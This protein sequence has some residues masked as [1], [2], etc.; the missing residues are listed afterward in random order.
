[1]TEVDKIKKAV[2]REELD[3]SQIVHSADEPSGDALFEGW[4]YIAKLNEANTV[5]F[6]LWRTPHQVVDA[7]IFGGAVSPVQMLHNR[8]DRDELYSRHWR[9]A[10]MYA[11]HRS[12]RLAQ[13]ADGGEWL[14][15]KDFYRPIR[16]GRETKRDQIIRSI[17]AHSMFD[18]VDFIVDLLRQNEPLA[19]LLLMKRFREALERFPDVVKLPWPDKCHR[20]WEADGGGDF[21]PPF[22][23]LY[24]LAEFQHL[25]QNSTAL[26]ALSFEPDGEELTIAKLREL[27]A[28]S[29]EMEAD[30]VVPSLSDNMRA[31]LGMAIFQTCAL[32]P[33]PSHYSAGDRT[34]ARAHSEE[35]SNILRAG[36]LEHGL[37]HAD[38]L[39]GSISGKAGALILRTL[40]DHHD[41]FPDIPNHPGSQRMRGRHAG[42][43]TYWGYDWLDHAIIGLFEIAE[44]VQ[45]TNECLGKIKLSP[46]RRNSKASGRVTSLKNAAFK[47]AFFWLESTNERAFLSQVKKYGRTPSKRSAVG[48]PAHDKLNQKVDD[49]GDQSKEKNDKSEYEGEGDWLEDNASGIARRHLSELSEIAGRED[50]SDLPGASARYRPEYWVDGSTPADAAWYEARKADSSAAFNVVGLALLNGSEAISPSRHAPHQ[51][52]Q[53]ERH[54]KVIQARGGKTRSS[55]N[56][57]SLEATVVSNLAMTVS[58][59]SADPQLSWFARKPED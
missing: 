17:L 31:Q 11:D 33:T 46:D 14:R 52:V 27:V 23:Y 49:E 57:A 7:T 9:L 45:R 20:R 21:L 36:F 24:H 25:A 6:G 4:D 32:L 42:A 43:P 35:Q 13:D 40:H 47:T 39:T 8:L 34:T 54:H 29:V 50:R 55:G 56:S 38:M 37:E 22:H 19:E 28:D 12:D 30:H 1:M 26:M 10:R 3:R 5:G 44:S 16:N 18:G 59:F 41:R 51:R 15:R 58:A 53:G 48:L 2:S